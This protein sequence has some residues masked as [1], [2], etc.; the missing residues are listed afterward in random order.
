MPAPTD[1]AGITVVG[2]V[3]IV[4]RVASLSWKVVA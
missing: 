1:G 2:C 4:Y 3:A